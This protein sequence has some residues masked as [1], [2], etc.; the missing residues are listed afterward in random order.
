MLLFDLT[1]YHGASDGHT[2]NMDKGNIKIELQFTKPL[3]D[4]ITCLLYLEYDNCVRIDYSRNVS[5]N[6]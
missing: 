3:P 1:P 4:A 5:C 2:S 6:F